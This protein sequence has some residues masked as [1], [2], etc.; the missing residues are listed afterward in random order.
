MKWTNKIYWLNLV[1]WEDN[2]V[3]LTKINVVNKFETPH[4]QDPQLITIIILD[5]YCFVAL[6]ISWQLPFVFV[7]SFLNDELIRVRSCAS[8]CVCSTP[9]FAVMTATV[10][11]K[12][13]P[14]RDWMMKLQR[15]CGIWAPLWLVWHNHSDTDDDY[16]GVCCFHGAKGP[17]SGLRGW[18]LSF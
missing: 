10:P 14:L 7:T 17:P 16:D 18:R 6:W 4:K 9:N 12:L 1:S 11:V 2:V 5:K 3:L 8:G 15:G 13:P